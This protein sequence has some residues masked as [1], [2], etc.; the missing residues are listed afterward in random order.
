M[1]KV[2][3]TAFKLKL[4]NFSIAFSAKVLGF[5]LEC[6]KKISHARKSK[7]YSTLLFRKDFAIIGN[8]RPADGEYLE[9]EL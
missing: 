3:V 9:K 2:Q 6:A 5:P 4:I 1:N 7:C 8:T